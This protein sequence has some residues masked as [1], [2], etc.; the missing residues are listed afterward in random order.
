[1]NYGA[2]PIRDEADMQARISTLATRAYGLLHYHTH[3]SRRS[4]SGFPDSVFVG[5]AVLFRE[6]KLN[7]RSKISA[8]QKQWISRLE[9]AGADA[10]IWYADDYTSG[11]VDDQLHDIA[12]RDARPRRR[13]TP[14]MSARLAKRLYL[15]TSDNQARAALLWE[16]GVASVE[17]GMW[18]ARAHEILAIVAAELPAG[19]DEHHEWLGA[20]NL[21]G[22]ASITDIFKALHSDLITKADAG[23]FLTEPDRRS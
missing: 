17:H 5:R 14:P 8:A 2:A 15:K 18:I 11:L 21:R 1:M 4:Q 22:R 13:A 19:G 23:E 12:P 10:G 7:R 6:L 9:T 16:A 20:H 3:D